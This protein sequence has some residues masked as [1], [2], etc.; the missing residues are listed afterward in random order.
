MKKLLLIIALLV[1]TLVHAQP[2]TAS[3]LVRLDYGAGYIAAGCN[4]NVWTPLSLVDSFW[5]QFS[6]ANSWYLTEGDIT[7]GGSN[8]QER[9]MI[10]AYPLMTDTTE[11]LIFNGYIDKVLNA[12]SAVYP[13][14]WIMQL[15]DNLD[16]YYR[17]GSSGDWINLDTI[18][19][20]L[21]E[22]PTL[23]GP[24]F[25]P[26]VDTLNVYNN[27][28]LSFQLKFVYQPVLIDTT[29]TD[30]TALSIGMLSKR[31]ELGVRYTQQSIEFTAPND[32]YNVSL[33]DM[34]GKLLF[35]QRYYGDVFEVPIN[36]LSVGIYIYSLEG[37][38]TY[39]GKF[40]KS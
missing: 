2:P 5:Q 25:D 27:Y 4:P 13:E 3:R 33:Y 10:M 15:Q 23:L 31:P 29:T 18:E 11:D 19:T 30:T 6:N 34:S 26:A 17:K 7:N 1:S 16:A 8:Y 24:I 20:E 9:Y 12:D 39:T 22:D 36:D 38:E 40:M 14:A 28:V 32:S 37:K 21:E 35:T